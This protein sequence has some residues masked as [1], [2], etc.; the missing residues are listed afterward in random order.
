MSALVMSNLGIY[1]PGRFETFVFSSAGRFLSSSLL[2]ESIKRTIL[3]V[4][5]AFIAVKLT[6]PLQIFQMGL[7]LLLL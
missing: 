7:S 1:V 5:V 4:R 3:H 2:E 6:V